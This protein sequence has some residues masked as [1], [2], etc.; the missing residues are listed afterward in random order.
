LNGQSPTSLTPNSSSNCLQSSN[1]L[2]STTTSQIDSLYG[3]S[4][5]S[6]DRLKKEQIHKLFNLA[7]DLRV[8]V[9]TEKDLSSNLK[10]K[11]MAEM[12]FEPSTRTQCSFAAAMQRL[13]GSVIYMDQQHS[14]V[15][16]GESLEDSVRMMSSYSDCIVIRHPEPG[17]ADIAAKYACVPVLNAGDGCGEHPTQALLDIFTIREE[18][19]TVNGIT[20]TMCGDLKHGRTVHSLAKLLRLYRVTIRYVSPD[21]LKMPDDITNSLKNSNIIQEEYHTLEEALP[22][23]DVLYMTRIQKERFQSLSDYEKCAGLYVVT[24]QLMRKAKRKMIVMHPLPRIDEISTAFDSD[25][26]AAYF[27]QAEYGMYI[28]MAL[29]MMILK[30]R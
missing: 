2:P 21:F 27:R 25:P 20:I 14:S 18:I 8:L 26:R 19:G 13:G 10:G 22:E 15:K 17:A 30:Q 4:I 5:I 16:K 1:I 7:H 3:K 23:T 12:F 24:P 28:R 9:S 11:I 29:L 6:V